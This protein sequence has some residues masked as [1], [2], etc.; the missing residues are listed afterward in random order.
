MSVQGTGAIAVPPAPPKPPLLVAPPPPFVATLPA[1]PPTA[2]AP[3]E[4]ELLPATAAAEPPP[5]CSGVVPLLP[6]VPTTELPLAPAVFPAAAFGTSP[7][8]HAP[9]DS[10]DII[11]QAEPM[12]NNRLMFTLL[13]ELAFLFES[14]GTPRD[15]FRANLRQFLKLGVKVHRLAK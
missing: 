2:L 11:R 15:S 13:T 5:V 8:L 4:L 10:A 3:A 9:A 1:K 6:P 7:L 12:E 14:R